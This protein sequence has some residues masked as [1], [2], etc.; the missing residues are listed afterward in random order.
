MIMIKL[1]K[2]NFEEILQFDLNCKD[3]LDFKCYLR[4]LNPMTK[5]NS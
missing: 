5:H 2:I 3:R 4:M 1:N